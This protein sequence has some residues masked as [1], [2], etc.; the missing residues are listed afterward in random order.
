[1]ICFPVNYQ[2]WEGHLEGFFQ[3]RTNYTN[4]ITFYGSDVVCIVI[5]C[6]HRINLQVTW[7]RPRQ[8]FCINLTVKI[9]FYKIDVSS[10]EYHSF[11]G[12]KSK[13]LSPFRQTNGAHNES[14][15]RFSVGF[16]TENRCCDL[17][18]QDLF[19]CISLIL[20]SYSVITAQWRQ[21]SV[22]KIV[23]SN[24][25]FI[26]SRRPNILFHFFPWEA[27]TISFFFSQ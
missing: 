1:M 11:R 5:F 7:Q 2:K 12:N 8:A 10:R 17:N 21:S 18:F 19:L 26:Y 25:I 23:G 9:R 27:N 4:Y 15:L 22:S 24:L 20:N 13:G 3:L 14:R 16:L 6:F